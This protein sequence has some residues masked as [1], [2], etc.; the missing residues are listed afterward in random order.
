M[1]SRAPRNGR[2]LERLGWFDPL[3]Q[4]ETK[5]IKLEDERIR[6]W[7]SIGAQPSDTV[8]DI[9]GKRD[10]L[11]EKMKTKWE[12]DRKRDR[13]RVDAILE[14]KN[15]AAAE[16]KVAEEAA[17]ATAAAEAAAKEAAK[18]AEAAASS[19]D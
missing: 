14:V 11:P 1:D 18:E 12:A 17:A 4:D 9:L 2:V 8:R 19:D 10:L 16:A 3:E 7:L 15:K 6:H 13:A 5:Q